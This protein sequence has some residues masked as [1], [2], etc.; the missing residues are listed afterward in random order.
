MTDNVID[1][2]S[3]RAVRRIYIGALL[4][5]S[6]IGLLAFASEANAQVS[7]G[8]LTPTRPILDA[9]G[10]DVRT[11]Q[12]GV[13]SAAISA[14]DFEFSDGQF[15]NTRR[16]Q[17]NAYI[18]L[19][20]ADR[21]VFIN[22]NSL[23]FI[24]IGSGQ[25]TSENGAE[26]KL[27]S[28]GAAG[29]ENYQLTLPDGTKVIFF[30]AAG[31]G[32]RNS[33]LLIKSYISNIVFP[34]G[35][36]H[37]FI[38]KSK[39]V[40]VSGK[41]SGFYRIYWR[42]Q[43]VVS[44]T[45]AM[46]KAEYSD[47]DVQSG[48]LTRV[49]LINLSEDYCNPYADS[50]GTLT[51][52][53]VSLSKSGGTV[54]DDFGDQTTITSTGGLATSLDLPETS[55]IDLTVS[56]DASNNVQ[57]VTADGENFTY[58]SSTSGS[59]QTTTVTSG[60]GATEIFVVDTITSK[61]TAYTDPQG[62]VTTFLYDS[63]GRKTRET[64]P[65]GNYT[66]WTYDS[67]GNVT[68]V[69]R[70]AKPGSGLADIIW[71][72]SYAA[73]CTNDFTCNKP[74]YIIDERGN[75]T[76]FTYDA[77][78][79]G[80]TRVQLPAASTG[81]PRAQVDYTYS[82]LYAQVKNSSGVLVNASNPEYKITQVKSC[83]TA[84]TCAGSANETVITYAYNNPNLLMTSVTVAAGDGSAS[85]QYQYTYRPTG[86]LW[87]IDGPLA[88]ADDTVYYFDRRNTYR[89][90]NTPFTSAVIYPDP[91]GAGPLKRPAIRRTYSNGDQITKVEVGTVTGTNPSDMTNMVVT[92][93]SNL[94]Y[95][96]K[97]NLIRQDVQS[98]GTTYTLQ[99]YSYDNRNRLEC[100][101]VRMN[102]ALFGSPPS[103]ACT[104]GTPGTFG[105]DR[106]TRRGY[107]N[108]DR[109]TSVRTAY[110]TA[111]ESIAQLGYTANS[112]LAHVIDGEL[113]RTSYDYD[114]HDRTLKVRYPVA[115]KGANASS[116]TD[117]LQYS[118]DLGSNLTQ[119]R[120]R[121]GAT[122]ALAYDNLNRPVSR[123][124][125]GEPAVNLTYDLAGRLTQMQRPSD[126]VT[127]TNGWDAL[128]RLTSESQPFGTVSYQYDS[129]GQLIRL[130]WPDALYVNYDHD[131]LGRVTKIRENGA[132]SGI[133]VLASYAYNDIGQR[134]SITYGNGT[135]RTYSWDALGRLDGVQIDQA[136]TSADLVIG[137]VG[138]VGAPIAY[139]P[140][141]QIVSQ[142][143]SNDSYAWTGHY[144]VDRNYAANGLNQYATVGSTSI[145]HDARGNLVT[146]GSDSYGYDKL[147]QLTSAPG[148]TLAF[149]PAGRLQQL[150]GAETTRFVYSGLNLVAEKST[151]GA[152]LRR[153]VPGPGV[154]EPVVW[155]EG[156]GTTDRRWLQADERGS[157]V[158]LSNASGTSIGI[159]RYDEY[160]IPQAGNLGRFQYTGQ[161]WIADIGMFNYKARMYSPTLGRFMQTDPIE[162]AGGL[163]W[164]NYV[165]SDPINA[166]D[167]SGLA[168]SST[169]TTWWWVPT[170]GGSGP[171]DPPRPGTP[172]A[173]DSEVSLS[174]SP[175][176]VSPSANFGRTAGG[177]GS[178]GKRPQSVTVDDS[179]TG[180]AAA[181][182]PVVQ[183]A[184][185]DALGQSLESGS[186]IGFYAIRNVRSSVP[187]RVYPTFSSG[188]PRAVAAKDVLDNFPAPTRAYRLPTLFVHTHPN[189]PPPSPVGPGDQG[190]ATALGVPVAAID[191]AGNLT[192]G[193]P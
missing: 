62:G 111:L 11:R 69:R 54:T 174:C 151:S 156:S 165:G 26:Y 5:G 106:I 129:A 152:I 33:N 124:P 44:S 132:T 90:I 98:G 3:S 81:A 181:F 73:T 94:A 87:K 142:V 143:R 42:V 137:K 56:Y 19:S 100:T 159:N 16:D 91:D 119:V 103:N 47:P 138:S 176:A 78:H 180:I 85:S 155:Y 10:V 93:A 12:I 95:D 79:G 77:T 131:L 36:T 172:Y 63:A 146:S 6:V 49:S 139:N 50:C 13:S 144:N 80:V 25:F 123:T 171:D 102:P 61:L 40:F 136:G 190:S 147:N 120:M 82:A 105:E 31:T 2:V 96:S 97:G 66:N 167:P 179:C 168:C 184:A 128:G 68:Q 166:V 39:S 32:E 133:G 8:V 163:N 154:D 35:R 114:G 170:L 117:Y 53:E 4:S 72:A 108:S 38:Y 55:N 43:S 58:A 1:F 17:L 28:L 37:Q 99:Q 150:T 135:S 112:Q 70:V 84:T 74:N 45:G 148:A 15:S 57:S 52:D 89:P 48:I 51:Q 164:Y 118:Y 104:L 153:Y 191:R 30:A 125:N 46:M 185:L 169:T 122:V 60:T 116:A 88:G 173:Y 22:G 27:V 192:C 20:G 18:V 24:S 92:S 14:L 101:A 75:R 121:D 41:G 140:A 162:Y 65:E 86:K 183:A 158:A 189:N 193:K 64:Y 177:S 59:S 113:N 71:T 109:L 182:D 76:D 29:S 160:G 161:T 115:A 9:R 23:K 186:E 126:G 7:G 130:T 145:T 149:D 188:L 134:A 141:G 175:E 34:D 187:Y 127:L 21:V 67:R 107:D 110:G 178:A 157:I 83:A